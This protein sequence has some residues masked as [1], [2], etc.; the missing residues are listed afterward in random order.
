M[1]AGLLSG[2]S[3]VAWRRSKSSIASLQPIKSSSCTQQSSRADCPTQRMRYFV[4][5]RRMPSELVIVFGVIHG[6]D[7]VVFKGSLDKEALGGYN[8][9]GEARLNIL[10]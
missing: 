5:W 3:A 7:D 8:A 2:A 1:S 9:H 4:N 6:V 10:S